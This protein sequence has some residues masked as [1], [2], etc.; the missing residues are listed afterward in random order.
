MFQAL[1]GRPET[2]KLHRSIGDNLLRSGMKLVTTWWKVE[3]GYETTYIIIA[4]PTSV[5]YKSLWI[6]T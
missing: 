1:L 4:V 3:H 6:N 5:S 2:H